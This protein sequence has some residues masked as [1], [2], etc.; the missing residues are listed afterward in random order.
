MNNTIECKLCGK[1]F[2]NNR[3]IAQHISQHH[4]IS[5]EDYYLQNI[6]RENQFCKICGNK[7]KFRN[8]NVGY[9]T[10]CSYLCSY[11]DNKS[12][13]NRIRPKQ[14]KETIQKRINKTNQ[15]LKEEKRKNTMI[16]KYG[17][18]NPTQLENIK[19]I[20]SKKLKGRKNPRSSEHQQKIIDS[21]R[22]NGTIKH[23][24]KTKELMTRLI[25][26]RYQSDDPPVTLNNYKSKKYKTGYVNDI[27]YRSSYE[28]I[29]LEYCFKKKIKVSSAESKDF[30]VPYLWKGK[31]KWYYPDFYLEEYDAIIEIKPNCFLRDDKTLEKLSSGLTHHNNFYIIDEEYLE[32]IDRFFGEL[33]N[34]YIYG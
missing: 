12:F 6:C 21:K 22:R 4:K 7:K 28:R 33:K 19:K 14:S 10:Y 3:A 9:L 29:F 26:D 11:K 18:E 8:M 13:T 30:R 17:V 32:N 31:R 24:Q 5:S 2:K 20:I 15:K 1:N 25:N 23:S 16:K 27:F 34:E